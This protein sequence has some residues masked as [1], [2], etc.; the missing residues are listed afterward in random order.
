MRRIET[1]PLPFMCLQDSP[2]ASTD[3]KHILSICSPPWCGRCAGAQQKVDITR[4]RGLVSCRCMMTKVSFR[5]IQTRPKRPSHQGGAPA[6]VVVMT[7]EPRCFKRSTDLDARCQ[8]RLSDVEILPRH[9]ETYKHS[10]LVARVL[11][12]KTE[13]VES[14][15]DG[16]VKC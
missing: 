14:V 15:R 16:L 13:R 1:C 9:W 4:T 2:S 6:G 8:V 5:N 7:F 10:S 3:V 11:G 12:N